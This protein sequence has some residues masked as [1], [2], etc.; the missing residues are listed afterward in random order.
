MEK[1]IFVTEIPVSESIKSWSVRFPFIVLLAASMGWL[2]L[3][4]L[5]LG[6][7][8]FPVLDDFWTQYVIVASIAIWGI[9]TFFLR[10]RQLR[11]W[12][13]FGAISP[14]LGALLVAP[15]ASFA[16][17]IIKAY[18]AFPIGLLTGIVMYWIVSTDI[19]NKSGNDARCRAP[20]PH[21][22]T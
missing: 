4:L 9:A 3:I 5:F 2:G 1:K 6:T 21:H 17:E 20:S 16:F 10:G 15:P 22:C 12:M 13:V 19:R 18:I 11:T 14:L 8:F 7:P